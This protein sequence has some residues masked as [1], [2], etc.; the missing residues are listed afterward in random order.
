MCRQLIAITG[1]FIASIAGLHAASTAAIDKLEVDVL[2][3]FMGTPP[4]S[5]IQVLGAPNATAERDGKEY[6][7]WES[8]KSSGAYFQGTGASESYSCKATF[9]FLANK[10]TKVSLLGTYSGDRSLCKKLVK[11]LL[12]DSTQPSSATATAQSSAQP[13]P[14]AGSALVLTNADIVKLTAAGLP[15]SVILA[16]IESSSCGF[17]LSTDALVALKQASVRDPIIEAM[18]AVGNKKRV[19]SE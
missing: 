5:I 2:A 13:G 1:V 19:A 18:M 10:L 16:K 6:L 4:A 12:D 8:G 3:K 17:D 15:D 11:P 14:T 9:E 7:T